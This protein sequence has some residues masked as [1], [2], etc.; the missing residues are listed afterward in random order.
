MGVLWLLSELRSYIVARDLC[1]GLPTAQAQTGEEI[2]SVRVC[3][4]LAR[5]R[6]ELLQKYPAEPALRD[7]A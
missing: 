5:K 1:R 6:D 4:D 7:P 3:G 2:M